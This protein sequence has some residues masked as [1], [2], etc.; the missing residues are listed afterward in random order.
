MSSLAGE[1]SATIMKLFAS[2]PA[3]AFFATNVLSFQLFDTRSTP[4]PF[5]FFTNVTVYQPTG[6]ES[7]IYPRY[8]ELRDGTILATIS[9]AGHSPAYFPIM[10][11]K[12]GGASWKRISDVHDTANGWGMTYQ[13]ALLEMTEPMAGYDVGTILAC[14]LSANL[15]IGLKKIDLYASKDGARTWEFKLAHQTTKD[16]KTWGPVVNDVAY[17]DE[18]WRPGM[19][20]ITYLPPVKK[21]ILVHELGMGNKTFY[22]QKWAVHYVLADSPLE[23]GKEKDLPLIVDGNFA[24]TSS[25]YVVWSPFGGSNG[26]I[27]LA[28]AGSRQLYTNSYGAALDKWEKHIVPSGSGYA[29]ALQVLK[30]RPDH[31]AIHVAETFNGFHTGRLVPWLVTVVDLKEVLQAPAEYT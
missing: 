1:I 27:V 9:L 18:T 19:T 26:T 28:D 29:R 25:P 17:D 12:D 30:D 24:P 13:P 31:V 11:S 23:F 4:E 2:I 7:V 15:T 8:T 16:L 14:G 10:E 6:N 22:G 20:V 5:S 3:L 21:W